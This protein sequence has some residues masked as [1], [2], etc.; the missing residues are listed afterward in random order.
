MNWESILQAIDSVVFAKAGRHL[1]DV[2]IVVLRGAW[3][4]KTYE[5]MQENCRYSLSYIKQA[6]A[7]RF[8][9][10]LSKVLEEDISKNNI[11]AT[12]ERRWKGQLEKFLP[13]LP[14]SELTNS[15]SVVNIDRS[16]ASTINT[17]SNNKIFLRQDVGG[18]P[19]INTF[20]GRIQELTMLQQWI[21]NDNCRIVAVVGA[22]GIG[23]TTLAASSIQQV[24]SQFEFIFWRDL[25]NAPTASE[26]LVDLMKSFD[27]ESINDLPQNLE[28]N[29][30]D[31]IGYLRKHRCLIVIDTASAILQN[32][33]LAGHYRKEYQSYGQLLKRL[34]EESH[35]SCVMLLSREKP[36]EIALMEGETAPV[37]SLYL[38]GLDSQ[39]REIFKEK[40][41]LDASLWEN[42]I[43]LYGGNPL[44]LKIVASTIKEL[45]GGKVSAFLRQETI[46]F[47]ELNDILDEQFE[48]ISTL[49]QEILYWLAIEY[50]PVSLS[51]LHSDI[52]LP[53]AQAEFIE[54]LESLL[55]R[56][57][58]DRT[59]VEEE[60]LLSLQQPMVSQ[61]AINKIVEN[62][63]IEIQEVCKSQKIERMKLLRTLLLIKKTQIDEKIQV[64]QVNL[65]LKPIKN[66]LCQI[67][68]DENVIEEQLTKIN[69]MLQG[70]SPLAV[71]YAINNINNL[72]LELKLDICNTPFF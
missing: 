9:K 55:R 39:A 12:V 13:T 47:G 49:E 25:R 10:L 36:R 8:W 71:G 56:S 60:I 33:S 22:G 37:R 70:K 18:V 63:C 72:L 48:C 26:F 43:I 35:Q 16:K 29:I 19:E 23:K 21:T 64:M 45:F 68:Q 52:L 28:A 14:S 17:N 42:L 7:P 3:E 6:A 34:G 58:I 57:L 66:R 40:N 38:K 15:L 2:E 32:D 65:I 50:K 61:Y 41:L 54:A 51:Q 24:R 4:A 53:I 46:V 20:Y 5:Q 59:V 69:A 11:R 27:S 1:K 31:L 30:P 44:A 62:I 67:F